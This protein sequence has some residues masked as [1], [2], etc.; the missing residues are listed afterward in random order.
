M[1]YRI[2]DKET[3]LFLRDDFTFNPST[4]IGLDVTPA[5]GFIKPQWHEFEV[6]LEGEQ[7]MQHDGVLGEWVEAE[8][9]SEG[10]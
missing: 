10:V 4:E 6:A 1:I 2:I 5:Q 7:P 8:T 9:Q 3:K